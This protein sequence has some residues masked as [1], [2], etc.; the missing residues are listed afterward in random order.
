[1]RKRTIKLHAFIL[2]PVYSRKRFGILFTSTSIWGRGITICVIAVSDNGN[3]YFALKT[4][5]QDVTHAEDQ[6][7][8]LKRLS[9]YEAHPNVIIPSRLFD[10]MVKDSRAN[11][12]L[13]PIRAL[14][15]D[16]MQ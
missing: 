11:S 13:G 6:A 8:V 1:M 5:W 12:S 15:D 9:D 7:V 3:T 10:S 2:V 16:E 14:L 4:S